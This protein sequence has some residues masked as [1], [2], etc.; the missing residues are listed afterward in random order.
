[1]FD[2]IHLLIIEITQRYGQYKYK[3]GLFLKLLQ[4][5]QFMNS[6]VKGACTIFLVYDFNIQ[7]HFTL[8]N[9]AD[10]GGSAIMSSDSTRQ[11]LAF[12]LSCLG[13]DDGLKQSSSL[14]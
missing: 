3:L 7:F 14:N 2:S 8:C 9:Q 12:L 10:T 6:E 13:M 5:K 4:A 11:M 1:V